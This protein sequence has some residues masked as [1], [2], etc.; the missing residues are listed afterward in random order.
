[1]RY[2]L[3]VLALRPWRPGEATILLDFHRDPSMRTQGALDGLAAA[4]AW[5]AWA[6]G[7][8]NGYVFA[9]ADGADR[10]VGTVGVTN[11]HAHRTGWTWYATMPEVRGRGVAGDALRRMSAWAHERGVHRLELGHRLNNPAS[12]AVAGRAGFGVEGIE[13]EKLEYDG[14]RFDVELHG[15]LATDPLPEPGRPV[16]VVP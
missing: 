11:V 7:L 14:T 3:G 15:R 2:D 12:C 4:E 1:M 5:I 13:R 6:A 8:D 10:P 9:I 16:T